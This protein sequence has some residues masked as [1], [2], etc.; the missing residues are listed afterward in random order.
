MPDENVTQFTEL[1]EEPADDDVL[2]VEDI[3]DTETKKV[4]HDNLFKTVKKSLTLAGILDDVIAAQANDYAPAGIDDASI[5]RIT[6]TGNQALTGI[7]ASTNGRLLIL[8]NVDGTDTLTLKH[9]NAGSA[10]SNRFILPDAVDI[11]VEPN[12]A[13]LLHYDATTARWRVLAGGSGLGDAP[14][15]RS[16]ETADFTM[17]SASGH[18]HCNHAS[19]ATQLVAELPETPTEGMLKVITTGDNTGGTQIKEN[20]V[21]QSPLIIAGDETAGD[22]TG[23]HNL[24]ARSN[25]LLTYEDGKWQ[26]LGG[27]GGGLP[28]FNQTATSGDLNPGLKYLLTNA[29]AFTDELESANFGDELVLKAGYNAGGWT[30]QAADG[31]RIVFTDDGV[32]GTTESS[33]T[34][35]YTVNDVDEITDIIRIAGNHASKFYEDQEITLSGTADDGTYTVAS[36][37]N[38]GGNTEIT[39]K[40]DITDGSDDSGLLDVIGSVAS[41]DSM[42]SARFIYDGTRWICEPIFGNVRLN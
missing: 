36:A 25:I 16:E 28:W 42:A 18:H 2:L 34:A 24:A 37:A 8:H 31:L 20:S 9:Q 27:S 40:E 1:A 13:V 12:E 14:W 21:D 41:E 15:T 19:A 7:A 23:V 5:V 10:A 30:A 6:L 35:Q 4:R 26:E 22:G 39:V 38:T 29:G 17:P 33:T 32:V 3:S 11:G